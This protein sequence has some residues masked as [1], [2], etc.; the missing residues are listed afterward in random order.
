MALELVI[1]W[2]YQPIKEAFLPFWI[3]VDL[4]GSITRQLSKLVKVFVYRHIALFQSKELSLLK[5]QYPIRDVVSAKSIS[6]LLPCDSVRRRVGGCVGIPPIRCLP[7]QAS[8]S[9]KDHFSVITLSPL[10]LFGNGF[11]PIVSI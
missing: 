3:C 2:S 6:E 1:Q 4:V 9:I 11:Q 5:L 7:F 10:Q 8:R